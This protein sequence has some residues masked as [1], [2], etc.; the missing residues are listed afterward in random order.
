MTFP[1]LDHVAITVRDME[2][3]GPW[4]R[5]LFGGDPVLDEHTDAGFRHLV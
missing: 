2:I 5:T 1:A 3:S 4:Y